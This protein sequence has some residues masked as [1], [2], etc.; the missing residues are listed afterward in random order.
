MLEWLWQGIGVAVFALIG[1]GAW[2]GVFH[3]VMIRSASAPAGCFVYQNLTATDYP[4]IQRQSEAVEGWLEA[5]GLGQ[6]VAMQIYRYDGSAH[7][8]VYCLPADSALP[9]L[10]SGFHC[11]ELAPRPALVSE[12]IWRNVASYAVAMT[13]VPPALL[14]AY[15]QAPSSAAEMQV[16]LQAG[17]MLFRFVP[18]A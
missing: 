5:H 3:R 14:R 8:V 4:S 16:Q 17:Q 12:F 9:A 6:R 13:R 7:Q 10:P 2:M 11:R 1:Y 15:G 18:P